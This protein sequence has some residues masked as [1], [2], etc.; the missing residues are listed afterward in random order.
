[1]LK[2]TTLP[3][4]GSTRLAI[5]GRVEAELTGEVESACAAARDGDRTVVV[6]LSGVTFAD[7]RGVETL[8]ALRDGGATLV[9][10]SPFL[11]ELL[12][13]RDRDDDAAL[14]ARLRGGDAD[15]FETMVRRYG[16]RLLAVATRLLRSEADARDAV[17]EAFL[18]AHRALDGFAGDARL[19]TWLHRIV[20]N[21]ALMKL[22]SR[23]RRPEE[24]IEDLLPRFDAHGDWVEPAERWAA[25]TDAL[26]EQRQTRALVRGA[27]D[28]LPEP[29]RT[30][31]VL[32]DIEELDTDE[33]AR[34]LG[35]T[36]SA[37]K[38]RL[39]RARQAL[40]TLLVQAMPIAD[41]SPVADAC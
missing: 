14:L 30:V 29:Y 21:T 31:L 35:L 7:R 18:A 9:G 6:D 41:A 3:A 40:R 23:R 11:T 22:R 19:S 33:A 13:P 12:R 34:V 28:R 17:Q 27:I 36:S 39:H 26:L 10:C 37:V 38:T 2:I 20:V 24:S 1:M 16:G 8:K 32:R 5:E 4:D 25:S 15:A